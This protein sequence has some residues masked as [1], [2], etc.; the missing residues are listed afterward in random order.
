MNHEETAQV[1]SPT[2]PDPIGLLK[3]SPWDLAHLFG[4]RRLVFAQPSL[5]GVLKQWMAE[6]H[7][8]S[9]PAGLGAYVLG[10]YKKAIN[11]LEGFLNQP[12]VAPVIGRAQNS[13]GNPD[14]AIEHF[15]DPKTP[16]EAATLLQAQLRKAERGDEASLAKIKAFVEN[17]GLL[18]GSGWVP[19]IKGWLLERELKIDEALDLFKEARDLDPSLTEATFRLAR[20]LDSKGEDEKAIELYEAIL[21]RGP[22]NSAVLVN[23]GLLFEDQGEFGKAGRCFQ[24]VLDACPTNERARMF[25]QD[26]EAS[27]NMSYD[28]D[29]VKRDD[30][31]NKILRTP[32][33]DFELSVRSRN[34][35][36]KMG[37]RTLGDLVT[38]TENELLSYKNFGETSLMEIQEI[39]RAKGLRLGMDFDQN[40][41]SSSPAQGIELVEGNPNDPQNRPIAELDLSVR[42]R[43]IIEM[44]KIRTIGDLCRKTEA[45]LMS[46]PNFGQT[47][48]NEIRTKLDEL[49]LSLNS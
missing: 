4:I 21:H 37:I 6:Q 24:G 30:K 18:E 17:P 23:L 43:R 5:R 7:E 27:R 35:L 31:R 19:Y 8:A 46:C 13:I 2:T 48:L 10:D 1:Q 34:C 47:S 14:W 20:L 39:L 38:K 16:D 41:S 22:A 40:W 32:I 44:F 45:E 42:A 29:Q 12:G 3:Q 28:E 9:I 26:A 33:T 36:S 15:K 25:L 49:G 11:Y